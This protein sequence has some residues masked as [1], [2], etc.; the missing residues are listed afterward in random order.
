MFAALVTT[1][2]HEMQWFSNPCLRSNICSDR[3][4]GCFA[5]VRHELPVG[6]AACL[7]WS[8]LTSCAFC[9]LHTNPQ[10]ALLVLSPARYMTNTCVNHSHILM[11]F[12]EIQRFI[13]GADAVLQDTH[14]PPLLNR[15]LMQKLPTLDGPFIRIQCLFEAMQRLLRACDATVPTMKQVCTIRVE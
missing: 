13:L 2:Q 7:F 4:A 15:E 9:H 1:A 12:A 3:A 10:A 5:C 8:C 14:E 6:M 11:C